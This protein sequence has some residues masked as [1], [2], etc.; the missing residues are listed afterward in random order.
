MVVEVKDNLLYQEFSNFS[1]LPLCRTIWSINLL[2][3]S[4]ALRT[5]ILKSQ[6][7]PLR[8]FEMEKNHLLLLNDLTE[9]LLLM[10]P[11]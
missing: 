3:I 1:S 10:N 4:A 2:V 6:K 8:N 9:T 7:L 5:A 11:I